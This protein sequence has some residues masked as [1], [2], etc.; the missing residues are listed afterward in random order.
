MVKR[1]PGVQETRV[2]SLGRE[3]PLEKE[4]ATHSSTLAWRIPWT[5]E[6]G[7]LQPMGL[8]RVGH[9]WVT[10]LSL[11]LFSS[12]PQVHTVHLQLLCVHFQTAV[13]PHG[14]AGAFSRGSQFLPLIP[15]EPG[16]HLF[17]L[18][19]YSPC[20]CQK[21]EQICP[22]CRL[23][24]RSILLLPLFF[25]SPVLFFLFRFRFSDLY[26]FPSLCTTFNTSGRSCLLAVNLLSFCLKSLYFLF[27]FE[28]SFHWM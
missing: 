26:H 15:H 11:L 4:M 23:R 6:P 20:F 10:F 27:T 14:R 5:Q 24:K 22:L 12:P 7:R 8:Q 2:R 19:L 25:P 1:L 17:H 3:D 9:D 16:C 18:M 21:F 28:G 13:L